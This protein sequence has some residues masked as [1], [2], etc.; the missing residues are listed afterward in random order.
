MTYLVENIKGKTTLA[1]HPYKADTL[2]G[3]KNVALEASKDF[4]GVFVVKEGEKICKI[5]KI[6]D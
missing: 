1:K 4:H 5:I 2:E 3:A 6:D